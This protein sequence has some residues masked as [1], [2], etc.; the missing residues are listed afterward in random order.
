MHAP[1]PCILA[2]PFLWHCFHLNLWF[3]LSW[4]DHVFN[5]CPL[6]KLPL[7][8]TFPPGYLGVTWSFICTDQRKGSNSAS[9]VSHVFCWAEHRPR[10][11]QSIF[12]VS[13][14]HQQREKSPI[15][16]FRVLGSQHPPPFIKRCPFPLQFLPPFSQFYILSLSY[17]SAKPKQNQTNQ[18]QTESKPGARG[19]VRRLVRV[20]DLPGRRPLRLHPHLLPHLRYIR[21]ILWNLTQRQSNLTLFGFSWKGRNIC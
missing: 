16:S 6:P 8:G 15:T 9:K 4:I 14:S 10:Q 20:P 12:W 2:H 7:K 3:F 17:P 13:Q 19:G 1:P 21:F 18:T 11:R 5:S